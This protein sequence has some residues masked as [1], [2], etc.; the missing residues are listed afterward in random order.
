MV[1]KEKPAT[2]KSVPNRHIETYRRLLSFQRL[3]KTTDQDR[4]GDL[5]L[6]NISD[7]GRIVRSSPFRRLQAKAQ[8]FSMARSGAVRTR[9]THTIEVS[10]YGELIAEPLVQALL[11]KGHLSEALRFPF[12]KTVSNACLLHDIGNPPFGHM[13]EYAIQ[14]WFRENREE[15]QKTWLA[16]GKLKGDAFKRHLDA[17]SNFDGNPH[18]FR[19]ITRLQWFHDQYG[20]NLALSLL[21]SYV[22]YLGEQPGTGKFKKKGGYF[23]TEEGLIKEVWKKLKLKTDTEGLPLQRHPLVFLMEAADDISYC[24]SDIEDAIE[25]GVVSEDVFL[26]WIDANGISVEDVRKQAD[27][28][29]KSTKKEGALIKNGAYHIFRIK[30]SG[31]LVRR[32]VEAYLKYE[33]Q[34]LDGE[35]KTSLLGG[36]STATNLL[37]V[38]KAFSAAHVYTS[39]EAIESEL[40]GLNAIKGLLNAYKPMLELTTAEFRKLREPENIDRLRE[41]PIPA[42]LASLLP[43]KHVTAYEWFASKD[44]DL[45]PFFRT[46]LVVDYIAGMT[47][48]HLLKIYNIVNGTHQFGIE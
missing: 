48:S 42:L 34:I 5:N 30:Y 24:L 8:V 7:T 29:K 38:L 12:I 21:A 27:K 1:P 36:D 43:N 13:G 11:A 10:N 39:R 18:G 45:E 9:L 25:Q 40:G 33:D 44:A 35:M 31:D 46:Q 26:S 20:L 37:D 41:Y 14:T 2:P 23:P 6:E 19:I 15:L 4:E 32:A 16:F 47:D 17:Y 22:K 28:Y 3:R